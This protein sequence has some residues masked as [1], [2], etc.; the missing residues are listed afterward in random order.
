M[1]NTPHLIDPDSLNL[2]V[3]LLVYA[4]EQLMGGWD[5]NKG[6]DLQETF[7]NYM[8]MI[9]LALE[10]IERLRGNMGDAP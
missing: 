1:S 7:S 5:R 8:V 9:S 2:P 10:E 3:E 6:A 4:Q